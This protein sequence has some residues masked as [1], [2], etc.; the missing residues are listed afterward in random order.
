M[1][2]I[3]PD[4]RLQLQTNFGCLDD[5]I[6]S[7]NLVRVLDFFINELDLKAYGF[8]KSEPKSKGRKPYNPRDLLKLYIYGFLNRISSSRKLETETKRNLEVKW[9]LGNLSPDFKT[10]AD[11]CKENRSV[12]KKVYREFIF[13]CKSADL[14]DFKLVAIDGSLFSAVNHNN[15]NISK[16]KLKKLFKKID[17]AIESYLE[18]LAK[19]DQVDTQH[20]RELKEQINLLNKKR[21][22]YQLLEEKMKETGV[23]QLSKTDPD[24]RMM[25]KPKS[26]TDVGY[27][28]QTVVDSKNKL[29]VDFEV[30]NDCNDHHQLF[31][32][33]NKVKKTHELDN[34]EVTADNGYYNGKEIAKC[35]CENI[36]TYVPSREYSPKDK[37]QFSSKY[38][39]YKKSADIYICP[40]NRE[41]PRYKRDSSQY[42]TIYGK[43]SV[44]EGC[45]FTNDCITSKLGFRIIYR[46]DY[47]EIYAYQN[48]MNKENPEKI[49]VRKMIVEHP[50]GTIKHHMK[51]TGFLTKGLTSVNG[52]FSMV[53]LAYNIKRVFNIL[54]FDGFISAI[55]KYYCAQKSENSSLNCL[56]LFFLAK[57]VYILD[58]R[59]PKFAFSTCILVK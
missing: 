56:L 20:K 48:S 18:E 8:S 29:I 47:T 51:F 14:I 42:R 38:F 24:S 25:S 41:L 34:L 28:V 21:S 54:G 22:E 12:L 55:R 59:S 4:N 7:N 39:K 13:I 35:F 46:N 50:F 26:K 16:N 32:M 57:W 45:Q 53:A 33:S 9:L 49:D 27:N 3:K 31:N 44:C 17:Q 58:H 19:T 40:S 5:V 23:T 10:I 15:K 2:Y 52:E 37:G 36:K 1:R 6:E 43:Q 30:T 11:F